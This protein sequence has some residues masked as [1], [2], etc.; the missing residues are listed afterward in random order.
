MTLGSA[1][2]DHASAVLRAEF[3]PISDMRASAAYRREVLGSL[4]QRVWLEIQGLP[5]VSLETLSLEDRA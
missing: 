4:L 3:E 5:N 1:T 2:F